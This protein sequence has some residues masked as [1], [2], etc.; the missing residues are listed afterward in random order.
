[1]I[2]CIS[3]ISTCIAFPK[4]AD[5]ANEREVVLVG[6]VLLT[7]RRTEG[8]VQGVPLLAGS[9]GHPQCEP[10]FLASSPPRRTECRSSLPDRVCR[11]FISRLVNAW[12]VRVQNLCQVRGCDFRTGRMHWQAL[13][14]YARSPTT[15]ICCSASSGRALKSMGTPCAAESSLLL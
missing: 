2:T 13:I 10:H 15:Q 7:D 1:M 12:Q 14:S 5:V 3:Q 11:H 8:P 6:I 4:R 9:P